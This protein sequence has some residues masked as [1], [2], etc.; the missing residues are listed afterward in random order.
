VRQLAS[1]AQSL[2][3]S[4]MTLVPAIVDT[5][6]EAQQ[7]LSAIVLLFYD[8]SIFLILESLG[9]GLLFTLLIAL[10]VFSTKASRRSPIFIINVVALLFGIAGAVL[11]IAIAVSSGRLKC[12]VILVC[13]QLNSNVFFRLWWSTKWH[14]NSL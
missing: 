2:T 4:K 10:F 14:Y 6:L 7:P 9:A 5:S 12:N 11:S 3:T 13:L 1:L 8:E